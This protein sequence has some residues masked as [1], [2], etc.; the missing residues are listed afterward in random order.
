ML[1]LIRCSSM[2]IPMCIYKHEE[3]TNSKEK[4][5]QHQIQACG[6]NIQKGIS[7]IR[8]DNIFN[9]KE[10]SVRNKPKVCTTFF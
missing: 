6:Q 3:M 2:R 7:D 8:D 1:M 4:Q 10:K 5:E 9:F